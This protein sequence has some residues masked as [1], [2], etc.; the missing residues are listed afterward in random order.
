MIEVAQPASVNTPALAD[1]KCRFGCD[2]PVG[3]FHV[4]AGCWCWKDPVQALCAHHAIKVTSD[5]PITVLVDFRP[6]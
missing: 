2:A 6:C 3:L 1:L 5:G 4:P